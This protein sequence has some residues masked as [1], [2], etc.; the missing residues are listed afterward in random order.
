VS[1]NP[2]VLEDILEPGLKIVF[3]GTAVGER[4]ASVGHYYAGSS[5]RF[6]RTLFEVGFTDRQLRPEEDRT[7][8][9]Y[10]YGLTDLV[11]GKAG[12]DGGLTGEDF[13][14]DGFQQKMQLY[15]PMVLCFVGKRAAEQFLSRAAH[16][17]IQNETVG[18]T[19]VFVVPS[20]SGAGSRYWDIGPWKQLRQ[21]TR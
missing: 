17:G 13:D 10:G 4:S 15:A 1:Y 5:N 20:T 2:G 8:L 11:K 18:S 14:L 21:L 7:L 9:T 6:W 3:C 12:M 16:Y 19:K